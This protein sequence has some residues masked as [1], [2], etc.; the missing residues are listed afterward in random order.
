MRCSFDT[1]LTVI[2]WME[3]SLR[4]VRCSIWK[5]NVWVDHVIMAV[6]S[7]F[8]F[9]FNSINISVFFSILVVSFVSRSVTSI[10]HNLLHYKMCTTSNL[11]AIFIVNKDNILKLHSWQL[12]QKHWFRGNTQPRML[13]KLNWNTRNVCDLQ[14]RYNSS[15]FWW[16]C[17]KQ[18]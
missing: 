9:I 12:W 6:L 2:K 3:V 5:I 1:Q 14:A 4:K 17:E 8:F 11:L 16:N 15:A 13:N 7:V 18:L 10:A